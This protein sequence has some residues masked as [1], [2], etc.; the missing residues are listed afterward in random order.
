M[1][2][3]WNTALAVIASLGGGGLIVLS[4]SSWLGKIWASRILVKE[5]N[6]LEMI[7]MERQIIFSKLH[8]EQALAIKKLY[9]ELLKI[10]NA[11]SLIVHFF[12]DDM[13]GSQ[14]AKELLN[15][16]LFEHGK[17]NYFRMFYK[18]N[19]I[20]FPES[21]CLLINEIWESDSM[22]WFHAMTNFDG[23]EKNA[24][25]TAKDLNKK[26]EIALDKIKKEFRILLGVK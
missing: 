14:R 17:S 8:E 21:L 26:I 12:E 11:C 10:E 19:E 2:E 23:D 4:L 18:E 5:Q 20:F 13:K 15:K 22:I 1:P 25:E 16:Q 7:K 9:S 3:P 24:L 6:N